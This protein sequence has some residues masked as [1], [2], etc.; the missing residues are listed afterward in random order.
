MRKFVFILTILIIMPVCAADNVVGL[1]GSVNGPSSAFSLKR[2][3]QEVK[4]ELYIGL[5]N[6]DEI[7]VLQKD[8]SITLSTGRESITLKYED[9]QKK[10]Y[11]IFKSAS[12][13][14][15]GGISRMAQRWW[16]SLWNIQEREE[17][18]NYSCR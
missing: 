14:V 7:R 5:R 12:Q 3:E 9:T 2:N 17:L 1:I 16:S 4:V 6:G 13:A 15:K 11:V 8:A 18:I 10:P